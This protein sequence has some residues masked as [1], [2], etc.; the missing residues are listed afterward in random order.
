DTIARL[1]D[2]GF[3]GVHLNIEPLEND[4]EGYVELLRDV[5]RRLGYGFVLSHATRRAGPYG[6]APAPMG[7]AAWSESFYRQTM[8]LTDQTVLMAYDTKSDIE[9]HYVA[10][11]KHQTQLLVS[12]GCE[13]PAHQVLIGVPAYEDV[14]LYSNPEI[15]NIP[16]AV[17]GVR[18]A[19][20]A[21]AAREA[22]PAEV[23]GEAG[24]AAR[25]IAERSRRVLASCRPGL[26][27]P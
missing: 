9:K 8:A 11:V 27:L 5:R 20:E 26:R 21:C 7:S 1:R 19:L 2:E 16:N 24:A 13:L 12:W 15:E 18:A 3:H 14:P 10:F 22:G 23:E 25:E 6:F 17:A 4:H